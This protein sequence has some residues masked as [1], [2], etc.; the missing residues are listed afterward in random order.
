MFLLLDFPRLKKMNMYGPFLRQLLR[1]LRLLSQEL[2][3]I[4]QLSFFQYSALRQTGRS[5]GLTRR[6]KDQDKRRH[7]QRSRNQVFRLWPRSQRIQG[8]GD[9]QSLETQG[10]STML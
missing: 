6:I 1:S 9:G 5:L 4:L 10:G 3:A 8:D 2:Y 7:H